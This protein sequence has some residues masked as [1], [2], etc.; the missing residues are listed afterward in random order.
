MSSSAK[1]TDVLL[2]EHEYDG[3]LPPHHA[4]ARTWSYYAALLLVVPVW[5]ITPL[6]W[7]FILSEA[8]RNGVRLVPRQASSVEK[9]LLIWA[10]LEVCV[11]YV[12]SHFGMELSI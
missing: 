7:L 5:A 4:H 12:E 1:H 8:W 6:S 3:D 10:L 11:C 9:I 2:S